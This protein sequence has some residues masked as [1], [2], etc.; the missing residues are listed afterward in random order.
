LPQLEVRISPE[1]AVFW[2]T[3]IG[4]AHDFSIVVKR[5]TRESPPDVRV[6]L[7]AVHPVGETSMRIDWRAGAAVAAMAVLAMTPQLKAG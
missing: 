1:G 3:P 7:F 2:S 5:P 6:R 4:F